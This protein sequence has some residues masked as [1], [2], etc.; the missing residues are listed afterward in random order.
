[1][2][3]G[4]LRRS[5]RPQGLTEEDTMI[6]HPTIAAALAEQ[7]RAAFMAEAETAR[8][9]RIARIARTA[10]DGDGSTVRPARRFTLRRHPRHAAARTGL[11]R[12]RPARAR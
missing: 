5:L 9:A 10:G 3:A 8:Q 7:R 12:L 1:M 6:Q 4:L 2:S 11:A